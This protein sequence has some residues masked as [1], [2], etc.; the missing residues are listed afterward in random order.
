MALDIQKTPPNK[1]VILACHITGYHDVNRNTTLQN[2]DY[3]LVRAWAESVAAA[4]LKG[5]LFHNNFSSETCERFQNEFIT[6]IEVEHDSRYNPNVYRYCVYNDFL[7]QHLHHFNSIF[8]TDVCDV[9][10]VQNPFN[11]PHF[12][13]NTESLFCGDEPKTLDDEW[14]WAHSTNLRN[15]IADYADYENQFKHE[16]LLNCGVVGGSAR[17]MFN[18][19]QQLWTIHE[20]ANCENRTAYTGDMGAFNYLARTKFHKHILHG[21]PVNTVFKKYESE[22]NDCWFRHK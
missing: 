14:M 21:A 1:G 9:V 19:I 5:I 18:F 17:M 20:Q 4:G 10:L 2:N 22:R 11:H 15:N 13:S 6:F 8:I 16:A 7:Q 12:L 3:E